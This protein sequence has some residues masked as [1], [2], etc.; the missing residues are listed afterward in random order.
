[1]TEKEQKLHI[2]TRTNMTKKMVDVISKKNLKMENA[3]V[4]GYFLKEAEEMETYMSSET[5]TTK[6]QSDS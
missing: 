2:S 3:L 5:N 4:M 1:M 6:K